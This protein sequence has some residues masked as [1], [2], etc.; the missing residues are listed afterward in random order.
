MK[1]FTKL[2]CVHVYNFAVFL[3]IELTSAVCSLSEGCLCAGEKGS[4]RKEPSSS[5]VTDTGAAKKTRKDE[6]TGAAEECRQTSDFKK[7]VA[8]VLA[9]FQPLSFFLT[10]VSGIDDRFNQTGAVS[11]KGMHVRS[12]E[13]GHDLFC[14]TIGC[15]FTEIQAVD[16]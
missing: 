9:E 7:T 16:V 6:G 13:S 1:S 10:K 3:H 15:S 12:S 5:A 11:V 14:G 4:K 2:F 8:D